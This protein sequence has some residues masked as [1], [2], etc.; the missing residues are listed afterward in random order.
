MSKRQFFTL[1]STDLLPNSAAAADVSRAAL[2]PCALLYSVRFNAGERWSV[3][4]RDDEPQEMTFEAPA[5]CGR[6]PWRLQAPEERRE[7]HRKGNRFGRY[8]ASDVRRMYD[9]GQTNS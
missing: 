4:R 7:L 3:S 6:A 9:Q 8:S 1:W 5:S 2:A